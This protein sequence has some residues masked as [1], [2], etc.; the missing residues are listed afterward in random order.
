M[1]IKN[2]GQANPFWGWIFK[3]V[4]IFLL[5]PRNSV[6][7][8]L[9]TTPSFEYAQPLHAIQRYLPAVTATKKAKYLKHTIPLEG[10]L[11]IVSELKSGKYDNVFKEFKIRHPFVNNIILYETSSL[12]DSERKHA[13]YANHWHTDDTLYSDCIKLFQLP[14]TITSDDGPL[15]F[16]D[17]KST[18]SN[19]K[20]L[21]FRGQKLRVPAQI[22]R[23]TNSEQSIFVDTRACLHKAGVPIEGRSRLMLMVQIRDK[24]CTENP[25]ELYELQKGVEPTLLKK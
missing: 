25:E 21:F 19:W 9:A 22:E 4:L 8:L 17:S 14:T 6:R 23:Y 12:S 24:R 16:I 5:Q 11:E 10:I 3:R 13:I 1:K 20:N 18:Q 7:R 2:L 15:E